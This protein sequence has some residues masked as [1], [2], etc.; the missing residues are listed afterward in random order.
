MKDLTEKQKRKETTMSWLRRQNWLQHLCSFLVVLVE[1]VQERILWKGTLPSQLP[2]TGFRRFL[3][4]WS[5][6]FDFY[7]SRFEIGTIVL[8]RAAPR[9]FLWFQVV[10]ITLM[11]MF[12]ITLV[13]ITAW[14]LKSNHHYM[15]FIFSVL[16]L[17]VLQQ[18]YR[19]ND[20]NH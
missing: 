6:M 12:L 19:D 9:W 15:S 8:K 4:W 7:D 2:C 11:F 13:L 14:R 18:S 10:L 3:T 1:A 5:N 17:C 20:Y 16:F